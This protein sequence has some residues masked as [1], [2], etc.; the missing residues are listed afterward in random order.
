MAA[1]VATRG[2][3]LLV[4]LCRTGC[5]ESSDAIAGR[6]RR[7]IVDDHSQLRSAVDSEGGELQLQQTGFRMMDPLQPFPVSD[8]VTVAP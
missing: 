7:G 2:L 8:D 4:Q 1:Q 3:R 6:L 5:Q